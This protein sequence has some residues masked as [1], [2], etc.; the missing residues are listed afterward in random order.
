MNNHVTDKYRHSD[1][2]NTNVRQATVRSTNLAKSVT[3]TTAAIQ[4]N[5]AGYDLTTALLE[6]P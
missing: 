3:K 2:V 4:A 6:A 1:L 5:G